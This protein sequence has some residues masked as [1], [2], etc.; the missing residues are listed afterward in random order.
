MKPLPLPVRE[1]LGWGF[2]EEV[3]R[4]L[5]DKWLT[6]TFSGGWRHRPLPGLTWAW[7]PPVW[8]GQP[9]SLAEWATARGSWAP[10]GLVKCARKGGSASASPASSLPGTIWD[11]LSWRTGRPMAASS[12]L[13]AS[14]P[15][16]TAQGRCQDV[17]RQN[18]PGELL[19]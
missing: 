5:L 7:L 12:T 2:A 9:A 15:Q 13:R 16:H 4:V 18:I 19:V 1:K 6:C 8:D 14:P 11:A 3:G 10:R 17:R